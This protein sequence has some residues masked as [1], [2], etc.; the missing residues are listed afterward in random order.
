MKEIFSSTSELQHAERALLITLAPRELARSQAERYLAE[1]RSLT[2]TLGLKTVHARVVPVREMKPKYLVGSG[3]AREIAELAEECE[4]HCI[5]FDDTISP[6]QQRNWERLTGRCV[7]DRQEV[8]LE[9]FSERARTKEAMTQVALARM[10]YSLPRLTRA[11]THLSRQRGGTRGTRGEGE[12]QLEMDRRVVLRKIDKLKRELEQLQSQRELRRKQRTGVPV[13]TGAIVGYTNAGKSSLLNALTDAEA[14][15]EN[16]LFATLD[17]TTKKSHLPGG[18]EVL[19]TDT[20]GFIRKLPHDLV[21]AFHSTLEEAVVADFL[22]LVIDASD[23]EAEHHLETTRAVLQELSVR[24]T[25]TILVF[26]KIDRV[27]E[28]FRLEELQR[29]HPEA[30]FVS[31][32]EGRGIEAIPE[33]IERLLFED[34]HPRRFRFPLSRYD[35]ATHLHRTGRVLSEKYVDNAVVMEA[36]VPAKTRGQ[37]EAYIVAD[38]GGGAG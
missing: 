27:E 23:P 33:A 29:D 7:I 11:W 5:V 16:K 6:A 12:T 31:V 35:L 34:L 30:L 15:V 1:L 21:D 14:V 18:T 26:N 19:F 25:P 28:Q 9:I 13:P 4:A 22:I 38:A 20:V 24:E 37:L 17:P 3:K 10:E 32:R 8:I 2:D 36:R